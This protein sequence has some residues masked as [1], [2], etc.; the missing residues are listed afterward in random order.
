[1]YSAMLMP[2]SAALRLT[3]ACCSD[4]RSICVRMMLYHNIISQRALCA[5]EIEGASFLAADHRS[6]EKKPQVSALVRLIA[7]DGALRFG[8]SRLANWGIASNGR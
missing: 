4:S 7:N 8:E 6:N 3:S 5:V 1:M 2:K